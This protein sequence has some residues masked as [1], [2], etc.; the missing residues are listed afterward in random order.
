MK[1]RSTLMMTNQEKFIHYYE[2]SLPNTKQNIDAY[3]MA[4]SIWRRK[5]NCDPPYSTFN[6]FKVSYS[7][8]NKKIN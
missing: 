3:N 1:V 6:S 5:H 7:I 2:E 8:F 4:T